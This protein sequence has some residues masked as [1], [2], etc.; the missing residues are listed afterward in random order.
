M[1]ERLNNNEID[2]W[3]KTLSVGDW[4]LQKAGTIAEQLRADRDALLEALE[5]AMTMR[6][7]WVQRAEQAIAQAK[8][9]HWSE[10]I[11]EC[12]PNKF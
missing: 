2:Q 7:G 12:Q 5:D 1:T 8:G 4:Q 9:D 10:G 11:E 6:D 3:I